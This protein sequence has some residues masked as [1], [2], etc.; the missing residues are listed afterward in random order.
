MMNNIVYI[1]EH[2][3][4]ASIAAKNLHSPDVAMV[5]GNTIHLHGVSA[6]DFLQQ[7]SWLCHELKHVEQYKRYG[8][9]LFILKYCWDC[10]RYGYQNCPLETEARKA[11]KDLY[12]I[13]KYKIICR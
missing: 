9:L 1:K 13:D 11:E 7:K 10:L 5:L 3:W 6:Q 8:F 12:L 4:L 2:S